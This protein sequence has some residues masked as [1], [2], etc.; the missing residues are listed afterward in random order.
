M[1]L[2]LVSIMCW[3]HQSMWSSD[4]VTL[5]HLA[6][7][8]LSSN[9]QMK[10]IENIS[11]GTHSNVLVIMLLVYSHSLWENIS[12]MSRQHYGA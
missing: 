7:I 9:C 8:T 5:K 6:L 12:F 10:W 11:T 2:A 4:R 3:D 1:K